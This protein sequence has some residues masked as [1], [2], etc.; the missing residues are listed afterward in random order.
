[1]MKDTRALNIPVILGT[2]R[3]G[4]VSLPAASLLVPFVVQEN[5]AAVEWHDGA[6]RIR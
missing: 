6:Q 4:R 3:K 2:T 5:G 1:M